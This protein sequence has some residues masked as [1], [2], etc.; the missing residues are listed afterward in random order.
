MK[1]SESQSLY[2]AL[3]GQYISYEMDRSEAATLKRDKAV[4][5]VSYWNKKE[6]ES[7][8]IYK[9][10]IVNQIYSSIADFLQAINNDHKSNIDIDGPIMQLITSSEK[11]RVRFVEAKLHFH[12]Y[13]GVEIQKPQIFG[14][15]NPKMFYCGKCGKIKFIQND[16]DLTEMF[17]N[18]TGKNLRMMQYERVWVCS[19]G[20]TSSI[21]P[22]NVQPGDRY[23][24]SDPN[25]VTDKNNQKRRLQNL[26]PSCKRL[27]SLINATD[28]QTFHPRT[29]TT[30]KLYDN[31]HAKLCESEPGR[32]L[33][34]DKH[35]HLLSMSDFQREYEK[36]L[37]A[38]ATLSP[39]TNQPT[40]DDIIE[41]LLGAPSNPATTNA[42]PAEQTSKEVIYKVLEYDTLEEKKVTDLEQAV[43]NAVML[44]QVPDRETVLNLAKKLKFKNIYSVADIEVINTAFGYTR[45]YQSPES[46]LDEK[47]T[48][49]LCAFTEKDHPG[50]PIFYN[51]RNK[52]E[53]IVIDLD[54]KAVYQYIKQA[55]AD[56]L[57]F[58]QLKDESAIQDWFLNKNNVDPGLIKPFNDIEVDSTNTAQIT[59]VV[60]NILHT[61][62]HLAL[63]SIS[64]LSGLDKDSLTEMIF[65]NLCSILIYAQTTQAIVLGALTSMFDKQVYD[66][67]QSIGKD[68]EVCP[69]DPLC[70][71]TTNGSC[72]AC[73]YLSEPSCEHF[74]KDLSRRYLY[75]YHGKKTDIQGFWE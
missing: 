14:H 7:N 70:M 37:K 73:T 45:R 27:M 5:K 51:I 23:F 34:L 2:K 39:L 33:I 31:N 71:E 47:E 3:P 72:L 48:F 68:A 10:K 36:L 74:N 42:P 19:C 1:R 63:Q 13:D 28:N 17:C 9:P 22:N 69:F 12:S 49:K 40:S 66:L 35:K 57:R 58:H 53:G 6:I 4:I 67:L 46:V 18:C 60:Y 11:T 41:Q 29:I 55:L 21:T 61:I 56:S 8:D 24:A 65:P 30:I 16:H 15:V 32:Q 43:Q 50:V 20:Y 52:T 26:C 62:S 75:G 38:N 59:K 54:P 25:G 64:K 44:N